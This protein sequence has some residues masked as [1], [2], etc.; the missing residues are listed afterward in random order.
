M[1]AESGALAKAGV[2]NHST[3]DRETELGELK[4]Q[5]PECCEHDIS[6]D[7]VVGHSLEAQLR[8]LTLR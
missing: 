1:R 3:L 5:M 4:R 2:S 8:E 7:N 6:T